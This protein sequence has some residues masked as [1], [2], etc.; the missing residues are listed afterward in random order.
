VS[1]AVSFSHGIHYGQTN[2][3]HVPM[4]VHQVEKFSTNIDIMMQT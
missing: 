4:E 1:E 3:V 2:I